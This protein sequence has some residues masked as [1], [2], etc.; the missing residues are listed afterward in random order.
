MQLSE[1]E[2]IEKTLNNAYIVTEKLFYHTNMNLLALHE[3]IT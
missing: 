2:N 1:D 3:D